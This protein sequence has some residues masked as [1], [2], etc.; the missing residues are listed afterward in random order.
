MVANEGYL[1]GPEDANSTAFFP[2]FPLAMRALSW[3]GLPMVGAGLL[4]SFIATVVACTYLHKLAESELGEGAG[5]RATLYL[6]VFPTAVFLIAPYS[7]A[8]FLA[9]AIPAFYY[10]RSGKWLAVGPFAALAMS[11]RAAGIFLV[12]GLLVEFL[13]QKDFKTER[14]LNA[15]TSLLVAGLPLL[16]YSLFLV[17][18][19]GDPFHFVTAQREGW[20]REFVGLQ[21][22]FL[23]TWRTWEGGYYTNWMLAWRLE[24]IAA[25]IGVCLVL[26]AVLKKQYGY[27]AYMGSALVA[28]I[29]SSWYYSIPRIILTWFPVMLFLTEFSR[30]KEGRHE[31]VLLFMVPVATLGVLLYTRSIWFF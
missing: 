27:A 12:I 20:G 5:R 14:T 9:G 4:L 6:T 18:E 2:G 8:L 22:A 13:R 16:A 28:L 15:I 3:L 25:L 17:R 29:T 19:T 7:E 23:N 1:S 26:W 24:I 10:A 30:R 21:A 11:M 31:M